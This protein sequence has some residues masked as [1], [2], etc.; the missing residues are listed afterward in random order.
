MEL[1]RWNGPK[2]IEVHTCNTC[3][4]KE[5]ETSEYYKRQAISC[6]TALSYQRLLFNDAFLPYFLA[7]KFVYPY[8]EKKKKKKPIYTCTGNGLLVKL[9][10]RILFLR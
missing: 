7:L 6:Y 2:Q 4:L 8:S 5:L 9:I 1:K 10:N 3:T